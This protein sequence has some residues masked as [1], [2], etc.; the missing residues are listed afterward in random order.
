MNTQQHLIDVQDASEWSPQLASL[1]HEAWYSWHASLWQNRLCLLLPTAGP[2]L[3][4]SACRSRLA[5]DVVAASSTPIVHHQAKAL[6]LQL[7]VRHMTRCVI[8]PSDLALLLMHGNV[9]ACTFICLWKW[10]MG[11][12]VIAVGAWT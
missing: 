7:L 2:G 8:Y 1:V 12:A 9:A 6:Q 5:A 3:L 11:V 4:H 10:L